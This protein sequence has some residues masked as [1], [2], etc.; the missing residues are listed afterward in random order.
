MR[1]EI[2]T[3]TWGAVAVP[4]IS[5][6]SRSCRS[7]VGKIKLIA[8]GRTSGQGVMTMTRGMDSIAQI[9]AGNPIVD[10]RV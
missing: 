7:K 1:R 8:V 4:T 5:R 10:L 6:L 3:R 9:K 2:E